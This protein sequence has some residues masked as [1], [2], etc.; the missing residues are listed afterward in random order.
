M[1]FFGKILLKNGVVGGTAKVSSELYN[2]NA[3]GKVIPH[4]ENIS[5]I[6]DR[7]LI[8]S[9]GNKDNFINDSTIEMIRESC[10]NDLPLLVFL[11]SL[12][13][14]SQFR[15]NFSATPDVAKTTLKVIHEVVA[16]NAPDSI[17]L[18]KD[19]FIDYAIMYFNLHISFIKQLEA[20][21]AFR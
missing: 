18:P 16:S 7:R 19:E 4:E 15:N 5:M 2:L 21:N 8:R 12:F 6:L 14:T 10:H 20:I 11:I 1:G 13:E 3:S 17:K 9:L